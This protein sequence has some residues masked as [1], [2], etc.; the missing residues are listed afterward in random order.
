MDVFRINN[1]QY[2]PDGEIINNIETITW[3][4]RY[5]DAGEF[6]IKCPA[7]EELRLALVPGTY[8]SHTE[9]AEI[10]MVESQIIDETKDGDLKLEVSGRSI[11]AILMENRLVT[12]FAYSHQNTLHEYLD[13]PYPYAYTYVSGQ[14]F[15]LDDYYIYRPGNWGKVKYLIDKYVGYSTT[16]GSFDDVQNVIFDDAPSGRWWDPVLDGTYEE[17]F[18]KK[19]SNVYTNVKELL[20]LTN[21]GIKV[22]RDRELAVQNNR[23]KFVVHQGWLRD[24]IVFSFAAGDLESVRYLWQFQPLLRCYVNSTHDG[25]PFPTEFQQAPVT[26][27]SGIPNGQYKLATKAVTV[28]AGDLEPYHNDLAKVQ[29]ILKNTANVEIAN[30]KKQTIIDAKASK[31]PRYKY[32]EDYDIGDLVWVAGNYETSALMRVVEHAQILDETGETSVPTFAP[33]S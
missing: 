33:F 19:L 29:S 26:Y 24:D 1:A 14:G 3:V 5:L 16:L 13:D 21:S 22:V 23:I 4:E 31:N 20:A 10:M 2:F 32:K 30:N 9:T 8:L 7:T 18:A 25:F 6:S 15:V 12:N 17:G 28:D 11:E 27:P